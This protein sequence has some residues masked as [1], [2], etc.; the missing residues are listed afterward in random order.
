[1]STNSTDSDWVLY[2]YTPSK[3]GAI[4]FAVLFVM[5][6]CIYALQIIYTA[7]KASKEGSKWS[8]KSLEDKSINSVDDNYSPIKI[9]P[10]ANIFI[11]FIIGCIMEAIGY[12]ARAVSSNKPKAVTPYII[13]SLLLLVAPALYAA[14][15]YMIFGRLLH[16]MKCQS[17]MVISARFGTTF[18]VAGDIFSFFLQAAGGGLMSKEKNRK[19]GTNLVTAGLIVQVVFFGFF[20]LNELR[21]TMQVKERCLFLPAISNRWRVLNATLLTSSVLIMIRSTVRIVEFIQGYEGYIIS[22]EIFIFLAD[23]LPM[24]LVTLVFSATS[25]FGNIFD[26]ILECQ[27]VMSLD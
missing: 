1:M 17:L 6:T 4:V 13:Q 12:I 24:L 8:R 14:T 2:Q 9:L 15:I 26:V 23:A 3:A 21:F 27:D 10:T 20:L 22:H 19:T 18:F 16:V 11:P 5:T 7:S 25:Y